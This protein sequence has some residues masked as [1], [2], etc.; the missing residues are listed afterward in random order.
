MAPDSFLPPTSAAEYI[1]RA[2][3]LRPLLGALS[4]R[5]EA[6]RRVL[7][8]ALDAL[9]QA[10]LFRM[11]LPRSMNGGEV[12]P[13]TLFHV[14]EQIAQA[15]ASTAWC[16]G[17]ASGCA[18]TAAFLA[19]AVAWKMF[20]SDPRAVLAWGPGPKVKAIACDGGYRVSGTWSFAS[21]CRHATWLGAHAP[22][23]DADGTPQRDASGKRIERTFLVPA[24]AV[25]WTDI[26][27]VMGLRATASD[28][29]SLDDHFVR[30]DHAFSRDWTKRQECFE[31]GPLYRIPAMLMYEISFAGV[32]AGIARAAL[33]YFVEFARTK[34]PRGMPSPLRDN[35]VVQM[36][37]AESHVRLESA[38]H[39]LLKTIGEIWDDVRQPDG[40]L[41]LEHRMAIRLASTWT[42]HQARHA[43]DFAYNAA[44]ASAIF[45]SNPLERRFRDIHTLTQQVQGR[46][47][48]LEAVGGYLLGSGEPDL[49]FI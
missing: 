6:E 27:N 24:Q 3:A 48:H 21:G 37:A 16:L 13:A 31:P 45:G 33:D 49:T 41:S 7:P 39:W 22:L 36:N 18:S 40:E 11:I 8:E 1:E 34:V 23:H 4:D 12:E 9:H 28:A 25:R 17:Q 44:G 19:P 30:N 26:W 15:D 46:L 43:V 47:S 2:R 42:I 35:T 29:F 38:R 5:M 20:G 14:M 32:A 10:G